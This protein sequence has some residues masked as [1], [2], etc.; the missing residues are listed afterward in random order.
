MPENTENHDLIVTAQEA[1]E[2]HQLTPGRWL[3]RDSGGQAR[4]IDL[5]DEIEND[6]P[7]PPRKRGDATVR[8]VPSFASYL[9]KHGLPETELWGN[10]D[11]ST[12]TAV[13]NADGAAADDPGDSLDGNGVAG[14]GDHTAT[15]ALL[16]SGD[17][18]DWT[19]HDGK[20]MTQVEFAEFLEDHRPNLG[21]PSP[22]EMLELAQTFRATT[23]G[24]FTSSQRLATGETSLSFT[25]THDA[26]AGKKGQIEIPD[27]ISIGLPVY[28]Q[29]K[30]YMLTARL[31]Y[32]ISGGNL[33]MGY[34][35]NRPADVLQAAF[36]EVVSEVEK[37]TSRTVW[38]T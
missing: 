36:D 11:R 34:K 4:V 17:W 31:R 28:D 15:L 26:K 12:I 25:E 5:A 32:R 10:R 29:G 2:P 8:D 21:K 20:Y 3:V 37:V 24:E 9:A 1:V 22:A 30:P 38:R 27:E 14:W 18:K 13:I 23:K 35:L 7:N 16:H 6:R 19:A 33:H